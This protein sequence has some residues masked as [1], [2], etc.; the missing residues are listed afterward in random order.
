MRALAVIVHRWVGLVMAGFLLIAGLTGSLLVWYHE[1]DVELNPSLMQVRRPSVDAIRLDPLVLRERVQAAFPQ[2][3]V[4]WVTLREGHA[5]EAVSFWVEGAANADGVHADLGFDEVFVNPYT[6]TITGTRRWG[7]LSQG[8]TN[9]MPFIYRLHYS[10]ALGTVGTW[11]FGII[12]VL[13]TIDCFVGAWLTLPTRNPASARLSPRRWFRRWAPAWKL[14]TGAGPYKLN[15]D[16]HRAGGLWPWA[17]LFVLAWSSVA[18]NLYDPVYKP[19]MGLFFDMQPD[20]RASLPRLE[21]DEAGPVMGWPAALAQTRQHMTALARERDFQILAED[22]LSYD[23]H[24]GVLRLEVRSDRDVSERRGR[25]S[26]FVDA[27]SGELLAHRLPTGEAAGDTVTAWL[28]NL[29]MAH[30]WGMSF[31]IFITLAGLVVAVLSGTGVYIWWK[32][33]RSRVHGSRLRA[34]AAVHSNIR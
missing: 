3:W 32:K 15:Y 12:A 31:R 26:V 9:L 19:V 6:G 13:W 4:H 1:L 23:P 21:R 24:R 27:R 22:R 8:V 10:L 7:D 18:F 2:A 5:D 33:R 30:V 16:L 17:A 20:P 28:L 11:I 29:H 14:R 34:S 25:T